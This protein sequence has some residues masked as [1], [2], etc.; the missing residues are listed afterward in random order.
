MMAI[1][2]IKRISAE[3]CGVTVDDIDGRG[4]S[5]KI[6]LAR[7]IAIYFSRKQLGVEA[8]GRHFNRIHSNISYTCKRVDDFLECDPEFTK[9]IK[10]VEA[11]LG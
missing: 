3:T 1:E 9:I 6:S 4:R 5:Q 8:V 10:K 2:D 11:K 7:Q